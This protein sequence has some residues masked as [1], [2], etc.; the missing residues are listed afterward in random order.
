MLGLIFGDVVGSRFEHDNYRGT[1]FE[2]FTD[3]STYTDDTVLACAIAQSLDGSISFR[4]SLQMLCARHPDAGYGMRFSEWI[5]KPTARAYHSWGNGAAV[6][7][8]PIGF[9]FSTERE[10]I[11][12]ATQSA[13]CTHDHPEGIAGA[14]AAALAVLWLRQGASALDLKLKLTEY[15]EYSFDHNLEELREINRFSTRCKQTI[16][17]AVVALEGASSV[18]DAVRRA[19][20]LGGDTDTIA[21]IAGGL[22]E[23]AGLEFG[24]ALKIQA[25]AKTPDDL[26]QIYFGFRQRAGGMLPP[27]PR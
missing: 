7:A 19:V 14:Q 13:L 22:A 21:A 24:D 5:H 17:P 25:L 2:L 1:D 12:H 4:D 6:R 8:L 11:E 15:F 3:K 10:V 9:A 26:K 23:A 27:D 16:T 18:E 20:S